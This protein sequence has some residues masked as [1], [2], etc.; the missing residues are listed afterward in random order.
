MI[1]LYECIKQ[2]FIAMTSNPLRSLLTTLG[3]VIGIATVIAIT[4]I[5]EGLNIAF[6]E[7]L[8]SIGSNVLYVQ[9][10][11]WADQE[12]YRARKYKDMGWREYYAVEK[13]SA[14]LAD[15]ISPIFRNIQSVKFREKKAESVLISGVNE[16]YKD[17]RAT[18]PASGRFLSHHEVEG[19]RPVCVLGSDV[20]EALFGSQNPLN[21]KV[22][23]GDKHFKVVGVLEKK[24]QFFDMNLDTVVLIPIGAF[25]RAYG[26]RNQSMTI[27]LYVGDPEKIPKLENNIRSAMRRVRKVPFGKEDDFAVNRVDVLKQ[28][29]DKLTGGLYAAM[30]GVGAVSLL[31]GGIGIM[32][33][34]LVSVTERTREIGVRKALGAANR[35]ILVQF[36]TEAIVLAALGGA[37]GVG[38]G[39]LI[40]E[41]VDKISPVPAAVRPWAV[42]LGLGFASVVGVIFGL[43]PA[44]TAAKK[45]PIDALRYE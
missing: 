23:I 35:L 34:M 29:Y 11:K 25:E 1:A 7:E 36:L 14:G 18:Y 2:A 15:Y 28:L 40:A 13:A 26:A 4:S 6:A 30:F 39:F 16:Q 45:N 44:R 3:I 12:W 17:I 42:V 20:A 38:F 10:W 31:V 27:G 24:G 5:I 8:A 22:L 19:A 32:N 37:I 41:V 33:I 21:H 43:F 9:K